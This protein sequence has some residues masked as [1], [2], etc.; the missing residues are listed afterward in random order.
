MGA[1]RSARIGMRMP[2]QNS[3]GR[4]IS[5]LQIDAPVSQLLERNGRAGHG[6]MHERAGPHHAEIAVQIFDFGLSRAGGSTIC[7]IEQANLRRR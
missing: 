1:L 2:L 7:A 4:R 3:L 6:A 5:F